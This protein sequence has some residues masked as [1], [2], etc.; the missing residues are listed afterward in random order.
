MSATVKQ[1]IDLALSKVGYEYNTTSPYRWTGTRHYFDCSGFMYYLPKTLGVAP[2]WWWPPGSHDQALAMRDHGLLI[3][4][5]N[6]HDGWG[7]VGDPNVARGIPGAL[8]THGPSHS[9]VG[10][11]GIP[12]HIAMSLGNG[13]TVEAMGTAWGTRI[14]N[15]DG[16]GWNNAGYM[17]GIDYSGSPQPPTPDPIDDG[18]EFNGEEA[19]LVIPARAK[20][21]NGRIPYYVLDQ[22]L[23]RVLCYNDAVLTWR[24]A[25]TPNP[26]GH[27]TGAAFYRSY[28]IPT[29]GP[30]TG[31]DEAHNPATTEPNNQL[32]IVAADGGCAFA[33]MHYQGF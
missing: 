31:M 15:F 32:C 12:G 33:D 14:G 24:G 1:V 19:M 22:Q 7:M 5:R 9:Y 28:A 6:F 8:V 10:G 27:G 11:A 20:V 4:P 3:A 18:P 16:R 23:D 21:V 17:P 2:N 30:H 26:E 25:P 29:K 13:R